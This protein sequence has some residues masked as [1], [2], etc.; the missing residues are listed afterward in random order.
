MR[1]AITNTRITS[2][3]TSFAPASG[4]AFSAFPL[5]SG[6]LSIPL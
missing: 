4:G 6:Q 5:S 3:I 1:G 2:E